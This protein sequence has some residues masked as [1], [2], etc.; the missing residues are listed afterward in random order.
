MPCESPPTTRAAVPG[1]SAL[2]RRVPPA[3]W[4]RS[5]TSATDFRDQRTLTVLSGVLAHEQAVQDQQDDRANERAHEAGCLLGVVD[6]ERLPAVGRD[7][8]SDDADRGGDEEAAGIAS[9]HHELGE[10]S[11]D[12][13]DHDDPDDVHSLLVRRVDRPTADAARTP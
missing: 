1:R 9:R 2:P 7:Q 11:N 10:Q 5:G 3:R 13:T 6:A 4:A 12:E 8:R